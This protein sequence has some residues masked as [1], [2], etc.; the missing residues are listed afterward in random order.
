MRILMAGGGG[1]VGR[2][3]TEDFSRQRD[4]IR[5]FDRAPG[6]GAMA[7]QETGFERT[8]SRGEPSPLFS[9]LGILRFLFR[10]QIF[11]TIFSPL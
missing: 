8:L 5:V 7:P 11:F 3:L 9:L 6:R 2:H 1:D 4:E 10:G